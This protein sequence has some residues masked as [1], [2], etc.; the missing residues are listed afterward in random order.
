MEKNLLYE[1]LVSRSHLDEGKLAHRGRRA[2]GF[3]PG[4]TPGA[5]PGGGFPNALLLRYRTSVVYEL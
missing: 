1:S 3:C 4:P 5:A 2:A